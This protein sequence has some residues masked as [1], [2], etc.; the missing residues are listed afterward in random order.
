MN[1]LNFRIYFAFTLLVFFG[2]CTTDKKEIPGNNDSIGEK[3]TVMPGSENVLPEPSFKKYD[4]RSGII[5]FEVL[6]REPGSSRKVY[7]DN[8]GN[9]EV[10][11]ISSKGNLS[12]KWVNNND[13]IFY[14]LNYKTKTGVSRKSSRTG[15][16]D[17]FDIEEMPEDMRKE[18]KVKSLP[19]TILAGKLCKVYS[20]E[21]GGI[22]TIKGGWKHLILFLRTEVAD[23]KYSSIAKKVEE[24]VSI[25]DSVY[26]IPSSFT[27]KEF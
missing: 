14:T 16:E 20:M 8:F 3:D 1:K 21:S 4:L 23:F 27:I 15:T 10:T 24:N 12:E 2:S 19:D 26:L 25:P 18:N 11:Y 22:K 5:T 17:R 13:G 6:G 9:K 7:F